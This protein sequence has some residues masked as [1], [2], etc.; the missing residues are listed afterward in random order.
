MTGYI[1]SV[2]ADI[3]WFRDGDQIQSIFEE[4]VIESKLGKNPQNMIVNSEGNITQ[5]LISDLNIYPK[6]ALS[7]NYECAVPDSGAYANFTLDN[8][9]GYI[10]GIAGN[11]LMTYSTLLFLFKSSFIFSVI[12]V[13][14]TSKL[15]SSSIAGIAVSSVI[16]L[17]S[18]VCGLC[19]ITYVIIFKKR[20]NNK[21]R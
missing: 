4:Y 2:T 17:F 9:E 15:N 3:Q 21:K 14:G 13:V 18:L 12:V 20:S 5:S 10:A 6:S 19:C 1:S 11:R 7:G 16:I 8:Q